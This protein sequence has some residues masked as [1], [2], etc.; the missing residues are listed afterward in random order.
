MGV[1]EPNRDGKAVF[2]A[3]NLPAVLPHPAQPNGLPQGCS[4]GTQLP[5]SSSI[6]HPWVLWQEGACT[7]GC[8]PCWGELCCL[9]QAGVGVGRLGKVQMNKIGLFC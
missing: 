7:H 4:L 1:K 9:A 5:L 6:A 3:R 8:Y 2:T